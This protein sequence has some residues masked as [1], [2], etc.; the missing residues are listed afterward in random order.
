MENGDEVM[1]KPEELGMSVEARVQ[2]REALDRVRKR[3]RP[4][5]VT[6]TG[7]TLGLATV[8]LDLVAILDDIVACLP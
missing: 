8:V 3:L 1:G 5:T 7:V 6:E 4:M 2:L